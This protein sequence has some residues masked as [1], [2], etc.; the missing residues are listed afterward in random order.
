VTRYFQSLKHKG[1]RTGVVLGTLTAIVAAIS[2]FPNAA[3]AQ[4]VQDPNK[5]FN[6][7]TV[8]G[9]NNSGWFGPYG[10]VYQG[11]ALDGFCIDHG[12][13]IM[14]DTNYTWSPLDISGGLNN[15]QHAPVSKQNQAAI[16]WA[17]TYFA[18][19]N[20]GGFSAKVNNAAVELVEQSFMGGPYGTSN[21]PLNIDA[22]QA[23]DF[24]GHGANSFT[25]GDAVNVVTQAK[26]IKSFAQNHSNL[27]SNSDLTH[28]FNIAI[29]TDPPQPGPNDVVTVTAAMTDAKGNSV[30]NIGLGID[31]KG[32]TLIEQVGQKTDGNGVA[33]W[34]YKNAAGDH[35]TTITVSNFGQDRLALSTPLIYQ[36]N[37]NAQ[38]VAVQQT[39]IAQATKT[40]T[41]TGN[42]QI[43]VEK[44][45]D[46]EAYVGLK[47]GI[48]TV[49]DANGNPVGTT[50]TN[51]QG[52]SDN[53]VTVAPGKYT[54]KETKAPDGYQLDPQQQPVDATGNLNAPVKKV[55]QDKV[56][57]GNLQL[58]KRDSV[59]NKLMGGVHFKLEYDSDNNGSYDKV[60]EADIVTVADKVTTV[61]DLKPGNYKLTETVV[62][63]G[64][65]GASP[66]TFNVQPGDTTTVKLTNTP[67]TEKVTGLKTD[68]KTHAPIQGAVFDL[69]R[70][71]AVDN[72]PTAP[73]E[74]QKFTGYTWV[75]Q[76]TSDAQGKLDFGV[77][78]AGFTFCYAERTPP[79]GYLPIVG[80]QCPAP[81]LKV[82]TPINFDIK[83]KPNSHIFGHK[84]D[85]VD[86]KTCMQNP[87]AQPP[88]AGATFDLY[89]QLGKN[90]TAKKATNQPSD[91]KTFDQFVWVARATS[92][93]NGAMDFGAFP[94]GSVYCAWEQ[95]VPDGFQSDGQMHCMSNPMGTDNVTLE[96]PNQAI[97]V[98]L[99]VQETPPAPEVVT[100]VQGETL[101]RTGG[102]WVQLTVAGLGLILLGRIFMIVS[103][104][105]KPRWMV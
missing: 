55:F 103:R 28:A 17:V 42:N 16:S 11:Q 54:I 38:R 92:D 41:T 3:G 61:A 6:N 88:L 33:T 84:F 70:K 59:T 2:F 26:R 51:A 32:G 8:L 104:R 35:T 46:D 83:D 62:P 82:G 72:P 90:E 53:P 93:T 48:F 9:D 40:L 43:V 63:A 18:N 47:G 79:P 89:R 58:E 24:V 36:S 1:T 37:Q 4:V 15:F 57:P 52:V 10:I 91:A 56:K 45:G 95:A 34:H 25:P 30:N 81:P 29:K 50:T 39:A 105:R 20:D 13:H 65:V 69:Y 22:L 77:R 14:P 31:V 75:G 97:T 21:Q 100:E 85:C 5:G 80:I 49:Y 19:S 74:A 86:P 60:R 68:E 87:S 98:V 102:Q 12:N 73:K 96:L 64:Y 101:A 27:V 99:S 23:S 7:S 44:H 78:T 67:N 66:K 94:P 71:G 76:A